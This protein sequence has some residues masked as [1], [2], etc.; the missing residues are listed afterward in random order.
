MVEIAKAI[1]QKPSLLILDEPTAS[2]THNET[3]I[4][5]RIL[6]QLK[7]K[8][9]G[10]IYISH[11]MAEIRQIADMISVLKDGKFVSTVERIRT[12]PLR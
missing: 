1:A 12:T 5:F 8:G 4:L 2:I 9:V 6:K 3:E 11:R 7:D 10:I